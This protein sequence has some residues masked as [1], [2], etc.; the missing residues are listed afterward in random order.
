MLKS[1]FLLKAP[2]F[3]KLYLTKQNTNF[4]AKIP[5]TEEGTRGWAGSV[6]LLEQK[7]L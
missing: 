5:L 3:S 2:Y 7:I 1:K 4:L 6:Y